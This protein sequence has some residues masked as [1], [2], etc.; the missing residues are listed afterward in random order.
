MRANYE[1]KVLTLEIR[2]VLKQMIVRVCLPFV[3]FHG[4][5]S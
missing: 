5:Y 1:V 3:S 2:V 4:L